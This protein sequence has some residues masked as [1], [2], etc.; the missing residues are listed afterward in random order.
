MFHVFRF[1]IDSK[2]IKRSFNCD[3]FATDDELA[4]IRWSYINRYDK[5]IYF[6]KKE[7][8]KFNLK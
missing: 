1:D 7:L 4:R 2:K 5:Q 8:R 6:H 3:F